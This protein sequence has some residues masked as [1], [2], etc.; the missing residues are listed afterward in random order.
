MKWNKKNWEKLGDE[1]EQ[2]ENKLKTKTK[3][4]K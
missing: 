3:W 1:N 2:D 4:A